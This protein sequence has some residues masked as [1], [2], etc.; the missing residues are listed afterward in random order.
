MDSRAYV[1]IFPINSPV[2][3]PIDFRSA[4]QDRV[5]E[6]GV[7]LPQDD[8]NWFNR[9]P[10]FPARLLL[11]SDNQVSIVAHP[12]FGEP[13]LDL[14]FDELVQLETGNIL[15]LGWVQ[16][17]TAVASH[18]LVYNTRASRSLDDFIAAVRRKWL[19]GTGHVQPLPVKAFGHDLEIKFRNL[20]HYSLDR[21]E[22]ALLRYFR[23]PVEFQ[24]RWL[25]FPRIQSR[26]G[27]LIALT[28]GNRLLWLKDEHR[29][30]CERYAGITVSAPAWLLHRC[31][32]TKNLDR[33]DFEIQ[34][35]AGPPWRFA[36]YDAAPDSLDFPETLN[37]YAAGK[38]P[39][40][41]NSQGPDSIRDH[42]PQPGC[43]Q[44]ENNAQSDVQKADSRCAGS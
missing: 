34:F 36:V 21:D 9:P 33:Y 25:V 32:A 15:L 4:V 38:C 13:A 22:A 10:K 29:G 2:D 27:H 19:R 6:Q 39:F 12:S 11:L 20:L 42:E 26:P 7:F 44:T 14:S 5:F 28:S 43:S 24:T 31:T 18:R 16:F 8:T 23:P 3:V 1:F 40:S 35:K 41:E 17:S 30:R 37:A